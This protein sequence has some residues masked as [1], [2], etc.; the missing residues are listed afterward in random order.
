MLF[1]ILN[2]VGPVF[3]VNLGGL[4][5]PSVLGSTVEILSDAALPI[6]LFALGGILTR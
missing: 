4:P 3:L 6:A 5:L 1:H 2:I